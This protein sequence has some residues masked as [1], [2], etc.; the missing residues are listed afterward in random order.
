MLWGGHGTRAGSRASDMH[1]AAAWVC[2]AQS[3]H[4]HVAAPALPA[5]LPRIV[6]RDDPETVGSD[7][8]GSREA[9]DCA[10]SF[11]TFSATSATARCPRRPP[12]AGPGWRAPRSL[13]RNYNFGFR[14]PGCPMR[15][16][17]S[18]RAGLAER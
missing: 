14:M 18:A 12:P 2:S 8:L 11:F 17:M 15:R 7:H 10:C 5:V 9:P 1:V 13:D 4:K 16:F 6:A 3:T